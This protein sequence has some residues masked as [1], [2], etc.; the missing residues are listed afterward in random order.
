MLLL[1]AAPNLVFRV[2]GVFLSLGMN[3]ESEALAF[4]RALATALLAGVVGKLLAAPP[5]ALA[6]TS[7]AA[8]LVALALA[9][10]TF[11]FG[12]RSLLRALIVGEAA[13]VAS[14]FLGL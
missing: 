9:M 13:L 4:I 8:R 2:V 12:G 5:G 6:A 10:A 1:A 3:E 7:L 14:L 11:R